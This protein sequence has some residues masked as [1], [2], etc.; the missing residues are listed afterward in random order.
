MG[1]GLGPLGSDLRGRRACRQRIRCQ[2]DA[3]AW[4]DTVWL[5]HDR[6]RPSPAHLNSDGILVCKGDILLGTFSHTG[7]LKVGDRYEQV[8]KVTLPANV[9]GSHYNGLRSAAAFDITNAYAYVKL[10]QAPAASTVADAMLTVGIDADNYYRIYVE[11][12]ALKCQK[13][14][15]GTKVT[16]ARLRQLKDLKDLR[17]LVVIDLG[18]TD[19]DVTELSKMLPKCDIRR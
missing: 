6:K 4:N 19:K 18:L 11:A 5:S 2:T 8:V 15:G 10:V 1:A 12:G 17:E 16:P 13:K 3:D 14:I 9:S 7:S